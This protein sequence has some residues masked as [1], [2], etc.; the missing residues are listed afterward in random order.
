MPSVA[1]LYR[2]PI[3]GFTPE[4]CES[5]T[6]L[7]EGRVAG[8]RVLG[9]RF[10]DSPAAD[11]AWSSKHEMLA[12][13][14]TPGLAR[15][16]VTFNA[17]RQRVRMSEDGVVLL[18]AALDEA[19]RSLIAGVLEDYVKRL[20]EGPLRDHPER[21]PLR[22]IGDGRT[23][24]YHDNEAGQIS[25]HGRASV[26][27]LGEALGDPA[28]SELRFRSNVAVDGMSSWEE[29]DWLG[30]AVQIGALSFTVVKE[31][32]RC[33]ATHA[34]PE[35]G[36]RDR[37]VMTGLVEHFGQDQPTMGIALVPT[38]GGGDIHVGDEVRLLDS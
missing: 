27:A 31:K 24:R 25:L 15:L 17:E 9:V 34:N 19:G 18:D 32:V 3:K 12:L 1:A 21:L 38:S 11:G 5:L 13:V 16:S 2:Y 4:V 33:L 14:N 10:A 6:I 36:E 20:G 22:V 35:T 8:D 26:A 23:P 28:L 7:P 30:R 29:L 37:S